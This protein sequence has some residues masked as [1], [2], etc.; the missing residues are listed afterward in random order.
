MTEPYTSLDRPDRAPDGRRGLV[1][2]Q[3]A[4]MRKNYGLALGRRQSPQRGVDRV[5]TL[6]ALGFRVGQRRADDTPVEVLVQPLAVLG[7]AAAPAGVDRSVAHDRKDPPARASTGRAVRAGVPP[8]R[9][10]GLLGHLLGDAM[11]PAQAVGKGVRASTVAPVEQL[12]GALVV[13]C[14]AFEQYRV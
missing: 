3:S 6:V 8:D 1:V 14:G 7:P 10:Q 13:A 11:A 2:G 5:S 9:D 4:E 12:I